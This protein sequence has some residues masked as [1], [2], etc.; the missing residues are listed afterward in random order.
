MSAFKVMARHTEMNKLRQL[1]VSGPRHLEKFFH[2]AAML[3]AKVLREERVRIDNLVVDKFLKAHFDHV[4]NQ[5][6]RQTRNTV[7]ARPSCGTGAARGHD[8]A[9][10]PARK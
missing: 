9:P 5:P 10:H 7:R 6:M 2:L 3:L 8:Q 4:E 1:G